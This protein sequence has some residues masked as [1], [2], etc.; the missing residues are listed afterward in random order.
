MARK[1][2]ISREGLE[3]LIGSVKNTINI[4]DIINNEDLADNKTYSNIKIEERIDDKI[5][6]KLANF[7]GGAKTF[8]SLSELELTADATFQDVIDKLPKGCNALLG[9]KEFTNY[10]TIFP[11]EGVN[12]QFAI[13]HIVKGVADG[14]C[15]YARWF[16]KDGSKEAIAIF[17]TNDNKFKG[18]QKIAT[19]KD[20]DELFQSVSSGKTLVANAITDKGVSTATDATFAT[21]ASNISNIT[22]YTKSEKQALATA[23]TDKGVS[24][25]ST[26]S[27]S[28]MASNIRRITTTYKEETKSYNNTSTGANR[29]T[30]TF[31]ADVSGVKQITP[32]PSNMSSHIVPETLTSMFTING[33][34]LILYVNGSGTWKVTALIKQ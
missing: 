22:N 18:W 30:F 3:F 7:G 23:I 28:T 29:L 2:T 4:G 21:M 20:L 34:E 12:D 9:V 5:D 10:Q 11:Y 27:F 14:S 16:R 33:K 24:T 6:E 13:V 25:S 8:T 32:P 1:T 31:S 15:M 19:Q 26:D 17:N